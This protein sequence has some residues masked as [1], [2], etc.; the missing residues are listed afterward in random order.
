MGIHWV[1]MKGGCG[2]KDVSNGNPLGH[3]EGRVWF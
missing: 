2:F 3:N 1:T